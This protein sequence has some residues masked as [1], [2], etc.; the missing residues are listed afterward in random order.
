VSPL[1]AEGDVVHHAHYDLDMAGRPL[2]EE[3][4]AVAVEGGKRVIA[5]QMVAEMPGRVEASYKI[6][7]DTTTLDVKSSS[8]ALA[9]SGK[10]A[11]GKLVVTGTDG[12][13]QPVALTEQLP[14]GAFLSAPGI[15]GSI[16]LASKLTGMKVGARRKLASLEISFFPEPAIAAAS[17]D[18]ERKP[19]ADGHRV[20]AVT[21]RMGKDT[22]TGDLVVDDQ[23]FVVAQQLG[24]PM[25]LT[26][27]R[28]PQ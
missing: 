19:D 20:F 11:R 16:V 6:G 14:T 23:G 17:Y 25:N 2:G 12:K 28:R 26:F 27:T 3:R 1:A 22:A 9:L 7:P 13:G 5:A 8:G 24:P 10:L 15:G 4:L 18:V 21:T